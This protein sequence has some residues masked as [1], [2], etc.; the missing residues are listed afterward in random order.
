M[1]YLPPNDPG[2]SSFDIAQQRENEQ[3]IRE[4]AERYSAMHGDEDR[5]PGLIARVLAGGRR[6]Q[7]MA[8]RGQ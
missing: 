2:S 5:R 6:L 1:S 4:R 7:S 8:R 3:A